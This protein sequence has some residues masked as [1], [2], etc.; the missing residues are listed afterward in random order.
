MARKSNVMKKPSPSL[1]CVNGATLPLWE[2]AWTL[3]PWYMPISQS[4]SYVTRLE[5]DRRGESRRPLLLFNRP[6]GWKRV[7][8][9]GKVE[10]FGLCSWGKRPSS[11]M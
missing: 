3:L 11:D 6:S 2:E 5:L 10:F 4:M 8:V 7:C 1:A 9:A